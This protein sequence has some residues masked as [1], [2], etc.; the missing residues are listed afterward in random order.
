MERHFDQDIA[1]FKQRLLR[2]GGEA[3]SA[4]RSAV[5]ALV[6][7]D[8]DL[9]RQTIDRDATLD[10]A[11]IEIDEMATQFLAK[12]TLATDLRLIIVGLKI[13][14][15]LERVGDEATTIARRA[16]E[17]GQEPQL[18]PYVDIPNMAAM[19]LDMLAAALDAFV[20]R[21]TAKARSVIP[22]DKSVDDLN[23][24]LHRELSSFIV[25]NPASITRA[26]N[27]MVISKSLE[28][29]ADHAKN[30]AEEVVFLYEGRD[31]RH[32]AG[33]EQI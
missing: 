7:R 9:A 27:L 4:V 5:R 24:Q 28:R 21:D 13:S 32:Q 12:G 3:E 8:D 1:E 17:L 2:M 14:H 20:Q 15:D 29:I 26:L 10:Q 31:I 33:P 16:I 23:K 22:R 25:E 18:K 6:E 19:A 11:E 30:V